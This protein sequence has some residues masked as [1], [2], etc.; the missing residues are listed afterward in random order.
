MEAS[1]WMNELA[2]ITECTE[3]LEIGPDA[4]I[5]KPETKTILI[6]KYTTVF[7]TV[8]ICFTSRKYEIRTNNK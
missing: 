7:V 8:Y 1:E 3:E 2:I 6:L 4:D 5:T